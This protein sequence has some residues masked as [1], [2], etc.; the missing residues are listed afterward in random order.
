MPTGHVPRSMTIHLCAA[1]P[2]APMPPAPSPPRRRRTHTPVSPPSRAAQLRRAHAQVLGGRHG[3]RLGHLPPRAV[4]RVEG[5]QGGPRHRHV[6]RGLVRLSAQKPTCAARRRRLAAPR[7]HPATP[8]CAHRAARPPRPASGR[9]PSGQRDGGADRRDDRRGRHVL[10]ARALDR[11]R[12]RR[13]RGREEGAAPPPRRRRDA[14]DARRDEDS[15]RHQRLPDGRPRRHAAAP[16]RPSPP[17]LSSSLHPRLT[18]SPSPLPAAVAK[19]Q[20]LKHIS[21]VAPRAVYTTGKGSS[22]VGLTAAVIRDG[23]TGELVLE[24]GALVLADKGICCIDEFDKMEEAD[25]TAI[26][27]VMGAADCL[28]RKGAPPRP[29][30]PPRPAPPRELPPAPPRRLPLAA[31]PPPL[32]AAPLLTRA[33]LAPL[34][35]GDHD[36]AQRAHV[37]ARRRQPSTRGT[38]RRRR[39]RR[40]STS[41]PPSSR[42]STSSGS[43]STARP[44]R[45]TSGSPSTSSTSR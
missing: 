40:T 8:P 23:A 36:D 12:D 27:E 20:L 17:L 6:P 45:R 18:A 1:A 19:S 13:P 30:A 3:H 44:G 7:R 39:P 32:A 34:A 41:P 11:P 43:S 38:T 33:A 31:R 28:D 21:T 16:R 22:G 25:R 2:R 35:G 14:R 4:R 42:A 15:R 9:L 5:A 29:P 24:G 10:E 26:H 37:G